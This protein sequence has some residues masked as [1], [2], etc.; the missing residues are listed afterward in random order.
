MMRKIYFSVSLVL[1]LVIMDRISKDVARASGHYLTNSGIS[2][3]LL[4]GF[5][6][7]ITLISIIALI[8]FAMLIYINK[9]T[10]LLYNIGLL[11][12]LSG[13]L[14]NLLDRL[15][16]GKVIDFINIGLFHFPIFNFSD[17]YLS[18]GLIIIFIQTIRGKD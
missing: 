1:I 7:L 3:G 17:A 10:Y 9:G 11:M 15:L 18:I 16:I 14:G 5:N 6:E 13:T 4:S 12:M 2:F 8:I